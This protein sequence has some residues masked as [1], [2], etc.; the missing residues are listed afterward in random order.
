MLRTI[1]HQPVEE[2]GGLPDDSG[3]P[4]LMVGVVPGIQAVSSRLHRITR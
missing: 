1:L 4:V 2:W 3:L